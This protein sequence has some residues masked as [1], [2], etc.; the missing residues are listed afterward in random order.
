MI[1]TA[2]TASLSIALLGPALAQAPT[3][4]EP[5]SYTLTLT[6]QEMQIVWEA[7]SERPYRQV[8]PLMAKIQAQAQAQER[9]ARSE[10]KAP[11]ATQSGEATP[12]EVPKP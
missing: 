11:S 9:A 8:A 3:P 1:R 6:P 10:P 2:L 4:Q 7:T 5:F 12:A